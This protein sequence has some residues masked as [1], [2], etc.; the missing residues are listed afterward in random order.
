MLTV[1]VIIFIFLIHV[2]CFIM[3]FPVSLGTG[4]SRMLLLYSLPVWE[5]N[6]DDVLE[7][8]KLR[9]KVGYAF[10]LRLDSVLSGF[11]FQCFLGYLMEENVLEA[12]IA[13]PQNSALIITIIITKTNKRQQ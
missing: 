10:S 13:G 11:S 4:K 8:G 1:F 2:T 7:N 12:C 5:P 3:I 9:L 6:Q